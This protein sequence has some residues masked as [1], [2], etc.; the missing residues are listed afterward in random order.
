MEE[1]SPVTGGPGVR[2]RAL[3]AE[4]LP[5]FL[6]FVVSVPSPPFEAGAYR[7]GAHDPCAD[8]DIPIAL[9]EVHPLLRFRLHEPPGGGLPTIRGLILL[10]ATARKT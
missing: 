9:S 8:P 10:C 3:K 1:R 4:P 2:R 5:S 6:P 7:S